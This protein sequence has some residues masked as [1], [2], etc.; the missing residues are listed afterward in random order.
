MPRSSNGDGSIRPRQTK[1][2]V[3]Y[4]VQ[5]T[6]RDAHTG[7]SKRLTKGGFKTKREAGQW[8]SAKMAESNAGRLVAA[9]P[10]TIPELVRRWLKR[11]DPMAP[12]TYALYDRML[13]NHIVPHLNVRADQLTAA[14]MQE[15]FRKVAKDLPP[16]AR[17]G[18][19]V[20][21]TC[22]QNVKSALRWA[23]RADVGLLAVNPLEG[24]PIQL[25]LLEKRRAAMPAEG[26]RS[27]LLEAKT[28]QSHLLWMILGLTGARHG[29]VTALKWSDVDLNLKVISI[30]KIQAPEA[31]GTV[32]ERVKSGSEREVPI[33]KKLAVDLAKMRLAAGAGEDD[34]VFPSTR[35]PGPIRSGTVEKWWTRDLERA[36]LSG[37]TPHSL[38]HMAATTMLSNGVP[39][40]VVSKILGHANASTTLN[41][42]GHSTQSQEVNAV[43]AIAEIIA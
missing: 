20:M 32:V 35:R 40:P 15:F 11:G 31:R 7:L 38:R 23:V 36:G 17:G 1:G 5:I 13:E 26:F 22:A 19:G 42:Y 8:R 29:E 14:K 37:Y 28:C 21:R 2:G 43:A 3:V 30:T 10:I 24:I 27:L 9:K 12:S 6:V 41:I 25:P 33:S 39:V 34:F 4:D 18:R 16:H